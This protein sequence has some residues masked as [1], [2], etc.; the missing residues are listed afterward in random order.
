MSKKSILNSMEKLNCNVGIYIQFMNKKPMG[1][2]DGGNFGVKS[3]KLMYFSKNLLL[4]SGAWFRLTK[5]LSI[6]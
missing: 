5:C 2:N 1:L 4:Y 3:V 6:T